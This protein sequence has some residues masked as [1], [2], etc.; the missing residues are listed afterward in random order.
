VVAAT[1]LASVRRACLWLAL[2]TGRGAI[3]LFAASIVAFG[4]LQLE[5]GNVAATVA[6]DQGITQEQYKALEHQMGLDRPAVVQYWHWFSHAI[7]G[8][9]G[10]SQVNLQP[11]SHLISAALPVTLGL[12][13][14]AAIL[15]A[16]FA[17]LLGLIAAVYENR[18]PDR[19]MTVWTS[20][21]IAAP[22]FFVG[23]VLVLI[24]ALHENVLPATG[25]VPLADGF[26]DYLKHL[27]LP[28]ITLSVA[29]SA[30]VAR[31][32]RSSMVEV[33]DHDYVRNAE[34]KG[35]SWPSVVVKHALRNAALPAVTLFG[36]EIIAMLGGVVLVESVFNLPGLGSLAVMAVLGR[37]NFVI[38]GV[39]M[40]A[41]VLAVVVNTVV[42]ASYRWLNPRLRT[43]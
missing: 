18:W 35:M 14:I 27:L 29:Y 30:T 25:Y 34:A 10:S 1:A 39:L 21:A 9:L 37:D 40:V 20:S 36:L 17:L 19:L 4:L 12:T 24:F 6:G 11:V 23:L 2:R 8:D 16:L 3:L 7:R 32:L 38:L 31:Q 15:T 43:E 42:D 33:M 13:I 5:K 28:A 22:S 41:C 26:G